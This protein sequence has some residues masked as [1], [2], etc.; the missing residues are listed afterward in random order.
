MS[1]ELI[2]T[3]NFGS[4][5]SG[6]SNVGYRLI[7]AAGAIS[8]ERTE[9]GVYET[10]PGSGI[11][12]AL[13]VFPAVFRGTILWDT[14]EPQPVFAAEEYNHAVNGSTVLQQM[15]GLVEQVNF[16]RAMTS[17]RWTLDKTSSTMSFFDE[18][19]LQLLMTY[20]LSDDKGNPSI[21]AVFDRSVK[22]SNAPD[23][24]QVIIEPE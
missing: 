10:V 17:G 21:E 23:Y 18:S 9:A 11:Y 5:K 4:T 7:D 19:G 20:A 12:A 14:G 8:T 15:N 6:L 22:V 3:A 16:I 13:I 2:K 1:S 24:A